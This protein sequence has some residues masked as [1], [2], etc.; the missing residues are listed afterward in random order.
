MIDPGYWFEGSTAGPATPI[1]FALIALFAVV[2]IGSLVV[3]L[4]RRRLFPQQRIKTRLANRRGPWFVTAAAIGLGSTLLRVA[5]FPI[6]SARI[7]WV[8]ALVW[9]VGLVV[10]VV[11]YMGRVY[12]D[13]LG[14]P[15][16]RGAAAALHAEAAPAS[17]GAAAPLER[18]LAGLGPGDARARRSTSAIGSSTRRSQRRHL[19]P[20]SAP[21]RT[22]RQSYEPQGCGLRSRTTSSSRSSSIRRREGGR[23]LVTQRQR[24][25]PGRVREVVATAR[26]DD[27]ARRVD[28]ERPA[29][30]IPRRRFHVA[31]LRADARD[32]D[33]RAGATRAPPLARTD[34]SR[35]LRVRDP[36][37]VDRARSRPL[38][39]RRPSTASVLYLVAY[40]STSDKARTHPCRGSSGR[41]ATASWP[42]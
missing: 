9:L 14:A 35:R 38:V 18:Q 41:G 26:V 21:S 5:Q 39:E 23:D 1:T 32:Q 10:Y 2:M 28:D 15:A 31:A 42:W 16:A 11:R 40:D 19:R 33:R 13:E 6:L 30:G 25:T 12:L 8:A 36:G 20:M 3:W 27:R 17:G 7:V 22:T 24:R 34:T 29:G 4:M 37:L